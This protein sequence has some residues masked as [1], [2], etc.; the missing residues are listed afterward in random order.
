MSCTILSQS[1]AH[2]LRAATE[3]VMQPL[4]VAEICSLISR[5][6]GR[7]GVSTPLSGV[8]LI[9]RTAPTVPTT[10]LY[11]PSFAFVAQGEKRTVVGGRLFHYGAGDYLVVSVD[12]PIVGQ[13][14]KAS[15]KEPYLAIVLALNPAAIASLILETP[16]C[17]P[18]AA[19]P[20]GL[21]VSKAP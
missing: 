8:P 2:L 16:A 9:A 21:T 20:S 5:H 19:A 18:S 7:D 6:A 1:R 12:L 15:L 4:A 13:V 3:H 17:K 14:V 11:E 10:E